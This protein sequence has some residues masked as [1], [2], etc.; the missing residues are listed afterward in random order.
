[1]TDSEYKC[2]NHSLDLVCRGCMKAWIA[3]HDKLLE[4][5][6]SMNMRASPG[7][8]YSEFH[9]GWAQRVNDIGIEAKKLLQEIGEL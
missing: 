8:V 1:M 9:N 6:K 2:E 3:R 7:E 4:F 5:V